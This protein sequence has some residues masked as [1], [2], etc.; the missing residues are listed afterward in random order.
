MSGKLKAIFTKPVIVNLSIAFGIILLLLAVV[1]WSLS[2]YT[3]HGQNLAVPDV[4]GKQLAHAEDILSDA[5]ME[6]KILDSV[7]ITGMPPNTVID[8]TPKPGTKVKG[9]RSIY[10]TLNAYN[11][12]MIEL[13][14]LAGKS[15]F[16]YAKMQLESYGLKVGEPIYKPSPHQNALLE[17]LYN[18]QPVPAKV[19]VPKGAEVILVIGQGFSGEEVQIP[20]LIGLT[21]REALQKLKGE[22]GLSLGALIV[23]DDITDTLN[24][25]V[26]R[27]SPDFAIGRK[28]NVG[29]E[30][31]VF[32]AKTLPES[33][34]VNPDFYAV[35]RNE[36]SGDEET[37]EEAP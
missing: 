18:G 23:E 21:Q 20:Y 1:N 10:V 4:T 25:I 36:G 17:I 28:L 32:V 29:E 27:Q 22:F 35:H 16:K 31:D 14:D 24:A 37:T 34:V 12:P 13:P 5:D 2:V 8:Q 33:V 3:R 11:V 19:K 26:Y 15:S 6:L 7:Y 9:G 30:I